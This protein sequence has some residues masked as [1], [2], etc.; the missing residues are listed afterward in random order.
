[1]VQPLLMSYMLEYPLHHRH[2]QDR[3]RSAAM[4]MYGAL[5]VVLA[6][7][8]GNPYLPVFDIHIVG[9]VVDGKRVD[10]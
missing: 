7:N 1:M 4:A 2:G 10:G 9:S 8:E 6:A 3:C 5:E